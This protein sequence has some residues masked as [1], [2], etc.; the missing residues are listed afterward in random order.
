TAVRQIFPDIVITPERV[1]SRLCGVRPLPR[2]TAGTTAEISRDH[3]CH[4]IAPTPDRPF[5]V[6]AL[7]GGKWTTFRALA[8]QVANRLLVHLGVLRRAHSGA[9][10]IGGG[11]D[12]P[13]GGVAR[14]Q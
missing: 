1:I 4:E 7:V 12:H 3:A 10:R 11:R 8:E 9:L 13:G 6:W 2:S 14:R 5:P